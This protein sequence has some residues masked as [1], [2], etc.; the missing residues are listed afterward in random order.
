[1]KKKLAW[2]SDSLYSKNMAYSENISLGQFIK[3]KPLI[4]DEECLINSIGNKKNT[5]IHNFNFV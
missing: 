2:T 5:Y 1:M 3:H 4:S